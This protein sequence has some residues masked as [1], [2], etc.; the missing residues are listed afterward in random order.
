MP[1]LVAAGTTVEDEDEVDEEALVC[2]ELLTPLEMLT[3]PASPPLQQRRNRADDINEAVAMPPRIAADAT[4][5]VVMD[6]AAQSQR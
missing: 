2:V 4:P 5:Q 1:P 6:E 3:P